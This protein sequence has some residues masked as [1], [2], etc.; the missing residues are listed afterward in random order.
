MQPPQRTSRSSQSPSKSN[1]NADEER[2][3]DEVSSDPATLAI[4]DILADPHAA[5]EERDYC[6]LMAQ[7]MKNAKKKVAEKQGQISQSKSNAAAT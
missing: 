4:N 3:R 6:A 5:P 7:Q 2:K 1:K